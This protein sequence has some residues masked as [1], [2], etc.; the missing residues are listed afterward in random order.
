M[1]RVGKGWGDSLEQAVEEAAQA[2]RDPQL[3]LFFSKPGTLEKAAGLVA[4]KF[5]DI[6][7][8]GLGTVAVL[9]DGTVEVP[10]IL[11]VSFE[12]EYRIVTGLI[13]GLDECPVQY[14]FQFERDAASIEAGDSDSV[15]IEYCTNSE[16]MLVTTLTALLDKF[17]IPLVGAT[18]FEGVERMGHVQ[19]AYCGEVYGNAC[20]YALI[21]NLRGKVRTYY[22]NIYTRTEY[23]VHQVTKADPE[24]RAIIELDGRPA[25]DVYCDAIL[26]TRDQI[27]TANSRYPFGR[28]LGTRVFVADVAKVLPD[29]SLYCNKRINTNDAICFMDYGRYR[30]VARET[31]E[32]AKRENP[33][34][35]F[36][37]TGDCI[38]RYW[39]YQSEKFLE[40]HVANLHQLGTHVGN[41]CGGEQ[42]HHQHV[43]Q[44]LVMTVFSRE[45][46][47]GE[48]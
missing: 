36:V 2:A 7:T 18:A 41:I 25:A 40:T 28:V 43:N 42:Y 26:I 4:D 30:E 19:V 11:L 34:C 37:L 15:C 33:G 10:E 5:P 9:N 12:E 32:R 8:M 35:Y 45:A 20:V 31:I 47:E 6:P 39:L 46:G 13:R 21:K 29:G 3:I 27:T 1:V 16:E 44:G 22:E 14:A 17:S 24:N 38:H 23:T 48:A